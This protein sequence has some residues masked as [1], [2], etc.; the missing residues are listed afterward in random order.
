[1]P[2][3]RIK[4]FVGL[5]SFLVW[6]IFLISVKDLKDTLLYGPVEFYE[7]SVILLLYL[8]IPVFFIWI[9]LGVIPGLSALLVSYFILAVFFERAVY[10]LPVA[11]LAAASFIGYRMHRIFE[12]NIK[13]LRLK[14]E[15]V[16]ER[17][18]LLGAEIKSRK[19]DTS[20][21]RSSLKKTARLKKIIEDYS[22]ALS[23]E[24][25][26]DS[27]STNCFELF[28]GANRALLYLVDTRKQELRLVRS[29]KKDAALQVKAKQGDTFD[30]WVLRRRS[31]LLVAD[32]YNDFR[33]SP[34][35]KEPDEGFRSLISTPLTSEDKITGLLRVDSREK[36]KFTQQDLRF[37][38]IIADLSSIS[39]E[40]AVLYNRAQDLAIHDGLTGLY[41][42]RYFHQR[43]Q[44]EVKRSLGNGT[45]ISLLMF[46]LDDFKLY[47]DHYGHSA[48]D[49]ALK[50][51]SSILKDF[52]EPGDI[53][54]R[55]GGEEFMLLALNKNKKAAAKIAEQIRRSITGVPLILRRTRTTVTVSVGVGSFPAEAKTAEEFLMLVD[56][57]LYRAKEAG[58]NR[59]CEK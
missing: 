35:H 34:E 56:S 59:V 46:D 2:Q 10:I 50:H 29:R 37:L 18:N 11:C 43:L 44:E 58:K 23:E 13:K 51:I 16:D 47:N 17:A 57:R 49:L 30:R 52:S 38:D 21:I 5:A 6:V 25:V 42:H 3:A 20:R 40:N 1:M 24:D 4:V 48:G 22:L 12:N 27:I 7:T 8:S 41:V 39:L 15:D 53:I 54:S 45:D 55:Y 36:G 28:E 14:N 33:F 19:N 32:A 26:L 31:P 9:T